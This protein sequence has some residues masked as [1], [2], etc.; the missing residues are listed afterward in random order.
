MLHPLCNLM[1]TKKFNEL[2]RSCQGPSL[3][4]KDCREVGDIYAIK[5]V[6]DRLMCMVV[7]IFS[8]EGCL[9]W[10]LVRNQWLAKFCGHIEE[11]GHKGINFSPTWD[12]DLSNIPVVRS[13]SLTQAKYTWPCKHS[14]AVN[15]TMTSQEVDANTCMARR[16]WKSTLFIAFSLLD[17][18]ILQVGEK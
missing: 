14:F 9:C 11:K 7:S 1:A 12:W 17:L 2:Q 15:Y 8:P 5:F 16:G 4:S 3:N 13:C 10:L 18:Y 6:A